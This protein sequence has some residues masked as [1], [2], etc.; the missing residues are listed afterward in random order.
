MFHCQKL[1]EA[2]SV[3]NSPINLGGQT[4][5][6]LIPF[7]ID[8]RT[9]WDIFGRS[10]HAVKILLDV[11]ASRDWFL[12][13]FVVVQSEW[14]PETANRQKAS[15]LTAMKPSLEGAGT[16]CK[17]RSD[18]NLCPHHDLLTIQSGRLAADTLCVNTLLPDQPLSKPFPPVLILFSL[19]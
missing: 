19:A 15:E 12:D 7:S 16:V 18:H 10:L 5:T 13:L 4:R 8:C 1:L 9:Q 17:L 11:P 3:E 2:T 14:R 6:V